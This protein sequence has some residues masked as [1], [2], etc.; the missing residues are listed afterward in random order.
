[1]NAT[2]G[3]A[4]GEEPTGTLEVALAHAEQL[5]QRDPALAIEQANE[6]LKAIPN[7]P[8]ATLL[9]GKAQRAS[10]DVPAAVR[11]L[12]NLTDAQHRWAAAHYEYGLTIAG[13]EDRPAAIR[14]LRRAVELKP[15]MPD[16][17][18]AL[19]D[20]LTAAGDAAGA[21]AAYANHIKASTRDPRLLAPAAALVDN[22]I[23]EAEALLRAHLRQFPTDVAALRMLA[24]VGARLGRF[25]DAEKLLVRC[26]ELAPSFAAARHNYAIVLHKLNRPAAALQQIEVLLGE[27][28]LNPAFR[29]LKAVVLAKVGDFAESIELFANV[30][31]ANPA[32]AKIW[33]S[34]GHAL[35]TAGREAESIAAYRRAIALQ[36]GCGEAYWSL[37]N[38]KTFRFSDEEVA[39]MRAQ[40]ARADLGADERFHLHFALG[41]ALEDEREYADSFEHY[42]RGNTLRREQIS[43]SAV[44]AADFV[45][46]SKALY[47]ADFFAARA[48][49]GFDAPDPIFI[50]GLP[51][52]G[53]TLIEQILASHSAV[54]GT[55]ELPNIIGI[56]GRLRA[57]KGGEEPHRY[58]AAV[59]LLSAEECRQL[60]EQYLADTRIQRKS[61]RPFFID[62]MPNNFLHIGL[63][64][65]ILPRAKIIDARRHPMA[66]GFSLFKQHFARGQNFSYSLEDIGRYY[67]DYV[68]LMGHF[69]AVLPGR[70]HR[71]IHE[72]LLDDPEAEIRRLLEYCG[73]EFEEACLRFHE[74]ERA[75]RTASAHQVRRPIT[76][77]G[78]DQWRHYEPWLA[79]LEAALGPV[80]AA[81]PEAP[82][83]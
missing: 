35:S 48:G 32:Q 39:A 49:H 80:L 7:Y 78:V 27:E 26:L 3:P 82:V 16:A 47:T 74:N 60:G 40:L 11:T 63:M 66:C 51:R 31:E 38:L 34:Y 62:K 19:G 50:V 22:R 44:D 54:E 61:A 56:A 64:Q 6:I 72:A 12:R 30:L 65:L 9:L 76:R 4:A 58:P 42:A 77:A 13:S 59:A 75:V 29:N 46:R 14:A 57:R 25:G 68:E 69:D 45:Q 33:M 37:A 41:K 18:R 55:M 52:A 2:S 28:P 71:V 23:P 79:P 70:I 73:L 15:D 17:W 83:F 36:P 53:S 81:Y 21:D 10:G 8:P 1:M 20:V 24:E 67:R 5:L 43:Y